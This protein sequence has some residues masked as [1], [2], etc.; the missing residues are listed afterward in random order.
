MAFL[1]WGLWS[2]ATQSFL[3][4]G[5][6]VVCPRPMLVFLS[7]LATVFFLPT[8]RSFFF[9]LLSSLVFLFSLV[10]SLLRFCS[11]LLLG[12]MIAFGAFFVSVFVCLPSQ[13]I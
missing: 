10:L 4:L 9:A 1:F 6:S 12:L 2:L 7:F 11:L 8:M 3:A 5:I 13:E